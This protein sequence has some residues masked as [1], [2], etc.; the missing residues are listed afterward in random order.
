MRNHDWVIVVA[1]TSY[2]S[3]LLVAGFHPHLSHDGAFDRSGLI[4]GKE[5]FNYFVLKLY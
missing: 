5:N 3:D 1:F 4:I 2:L